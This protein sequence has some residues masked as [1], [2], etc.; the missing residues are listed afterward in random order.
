MVGG[1]VIECQ[2]TYWV[3]GPSFYTIKSRHAPHLY[4]GLG[5]APTKQDEF[6]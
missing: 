2:L 4:L 5:K 1:E 6:V 3:Q